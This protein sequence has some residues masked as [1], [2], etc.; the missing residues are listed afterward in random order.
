MVIAV[1]IYMNL[2]IVSHPL[3][4]LCAIEAKNKFNHDGSA[5]V[6]LN[7]NKNIYIFDK[8]LKNEYFNH[9]YRFNLDSQNVVCKLLMLLQ[10]VFLIR[11]ELKFLKIDNQFTG[12]LSLI[13][14]ILFL[15]IKS[16]KTILIDD[17]S[18]TLN[19]NK[20]FENLKNYPK[21]IFY[22]FLLKMA[23]LKIDMDGKYFDMFTL[24]YEEDYS[25]CSFIRTI[26]KNNFVFIKKKY[27]DIKEKSYNMNEVWIVG[28]PLS[29]HSILNDV[30]SEILILKDVC[31]YYKTKNLKTIY[32]PHRF[33]SLKKLSMIQKVLDIQVQSLNNMI[34]L[35][36][37]SAFHLP[38]HLCTFCS[39]AGITIHKLNESISVEMYRIDERYFHS[40]EKMNKICLLQYKMNKYYNIPFIN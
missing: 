19:I 15:N 16:N 31:Y 36:F 20:S 37:L 18:A 35:Y 40:T 13:H 26:Y 10:L 38:N 8:L 27:T 23:G 11:F 30:V 2:F 6:L 22:R 39:T 24:F 33:D 34:E 17:G 25:A 4:L 21:N 7:R 28:Q 32:I 9:I 29:E 12:S 3:Q 5:L 1:N 14:K